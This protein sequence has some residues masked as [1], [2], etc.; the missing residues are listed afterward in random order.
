M[1]AL[2]RVVSIVLGVLYIL[3]GWIWLYALAITVMPLGLLGLFFW[4]L[5]RKT[6]VLPGAN[7]RWNKIALYTNVFGFI[8]SAMAFLLWYI[9]AK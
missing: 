9:F 3:L 7:N 6:E 8:S 5:A 1:A 4:W 2:C